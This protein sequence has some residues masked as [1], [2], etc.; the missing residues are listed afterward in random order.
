MKMGKEA[1]S[2]FRK[3]HRRGFKDQQITIRG[4]VVSVTLECDV[5]MESG[6]YDCIEG[7]GSSVLSALRQCE[8]EYQ[9][10]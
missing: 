3:F 1:E 4:G 5:P 6:G 9:A 8:I 2:L 10:R 7:I